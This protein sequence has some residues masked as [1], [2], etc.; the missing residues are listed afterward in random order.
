MQKMKLS[1]LGIGDSNCDFA[2]FTYIYILQVYFTF[3]FFVNR[4]QV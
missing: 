3:S 2:E 1:K 4:L